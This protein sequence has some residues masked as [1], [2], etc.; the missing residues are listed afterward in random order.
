MT[1]G[2]AAAISI[3]PRDGSFRGEEWRGRE[4]VAAGARRWC[5]AG[6]SHEAPTPS[7]PN[8]RLDLKALG[9]ELVGTYR[10][11][12]FKA[13]AWRDVSWWQ[14]ILG[15]ADAGRPPEPLGPQRLR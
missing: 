6:R 1:A 14:R 2:H 11:I 9:F 15:R 12:G 5:N 7:G 3:D 10:E 8:R 4:H 13:G